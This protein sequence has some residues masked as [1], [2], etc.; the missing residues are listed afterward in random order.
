MMPGF[1]LPACL[2]EIA[3]AIEWIP[4]AT[5]LNMTFECRETLEG[6][7]NRIFNT[8]LVQRLY[9]R[10]A[11][12]STIHAHLDKHARQHQTDL[13]DT[14]QNE[15]LSTQIER[16][17][18]KKGQA[19]PRM[20]A[21]SK[22]AEQLTEQVERI[23]EE[24]SEM[25]SRF[26]RVAREL[27]QLKSGSSGLRSGIDA[28][29][30]RLDGA[31]NG[32]EASLD[33]GQVVESWLDKL[34]GADS[35]LSQRLE[36]QQEQVA[37]LLERT[38]SLDQASDRGTENY[39][40]LEERLGE[41][42]GKLE[43]AQKQLAE[44]ESE[45]GAESN[46]FKS[47]QQR[48]SGKYGRLRGGLI[49]MTLLLLL[50]GGLAYWASW[51]RM[52]QLTAE[53]SRK[54]DRISEQVA[55]QEHRLS[56]QERQATEGRRADEA[57][58]TLDQS[59]WKTLQEE[60]NQRL[61]MVT[62]EM[63]AGLQQFKAAESGLVGKLDQIAQAEEARAGDYAG[64][65]DWQQGVERRLE[66]LARS[67]ESMGSMIEASQEDQRGVEGE[68]KSFAQNQETAD[69]RLQESAAK[70]S[71]LEKRLQAL[72]SN[73]EMLAA[74]LTQYN[75]GQQN[76]EERQSGLMQR[77]EELAM[78]VQASTEG[79]EEIVSRLLR[80]GD[81]QDELRRRIEQ[82]HKLVGSLSD[83]YADWKEAMDKQD[84]KIRSI[85]ERLREVNTRLESQSAPDKRGAPLK[86]TS[87]GE[88]ASG[89]TIQLVGAHNRKIVERIAESSGLS[90]SIVIY[91]GQLDGR[92]WHVLLYGI[93]SSLAEARSTLQELPAEIR[94]YQP[95]IRNLSDVRENLQEP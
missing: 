67:H 14:V 32:L 62:Q 74:R 77:Q 35:A 43:T 81:D 72:N 42:Q 38:Q 46:E 8:L 85:E 63:N 90:E 34:K 57:T 31:I 73:Q 60:I 82:A 69:S 47:E 15:R 95:W 10:V 22:Q 44:R 53:S 37:E 13:L 88:S 87:I 28:L 18:E 78:R 20:N 79:Q 2:E 11:E 25:Q 91:R 21:L 89:Y 4:A 68:L 23:Q 58:Q 66:S 94:S 17:Q 93:Y 36:Q 26:E 7:A 76:T 9:N 39:Q 51:G 71:A 92:A 40:A 80:Y 65:A 30:V 54:I 12:K 16:I 52:D 56:E 41:L 24:K 70:F 3:L 45:L 61:A 29:S 50:L 27:D 33:Q 1:R 64:I 48:L 6:N 55:K 49:L 19:E 75:E 84:A 59:R 5:F 86:Q 83:D